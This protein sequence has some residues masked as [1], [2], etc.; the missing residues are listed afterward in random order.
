LDFGNA[1]SLGDQPS[2]GRP[3]PSTNRERSEMATKV[4]GADS[5]G[6]DPFHR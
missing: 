1:Q 3:I 5:V 4:W 2:S 6:C